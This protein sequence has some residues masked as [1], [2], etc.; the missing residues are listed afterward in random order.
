MYRV[1]FIIGLALLAGVAQSADQSRSAAVERIR[2]AVASVR[3]V[4]YTPTDLRIVAGEV[5]PASAQQI[6]KDLAALREDFQGL[7]MYSGNNGLEEVPAIAHELGFQALILGTWDIASADEI[8]NVIRLARA[9]PELIVGVSVGNEVLLAER[10]EWAMLR[11]A[12]QRLRAALP[13]V[14]V[15]TS[16]PF[17]FYLNE[18]PPDFLSV[19]DFLLPSVH[20]LFETWFP[21]A[22]T[23]RA[24][25]FVVQVAARLTAK[26]DKPV[27]IKETGLPSGPPERGFTLARQTEFWVELSQRLPPAAG[28]GLVYFE[29]FDHAWKVEN[30]EAEFGLRPE[31]AFWGLYEEHGKHKPVIK[32]L[33]RVWD[34]QSRTSGR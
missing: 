15:T 10:H 6:R 4:A 8:A 25:D 28:A 30:A 20:P 18:D 21:E 16:E 9:Y 12:I 7:V 34:A 17:Y 23:E 13:Q 24:V 19:Q 31:E 33:R 1:L 2:A 29:A 5:R 11:D 32:A 3:F 14:A 27:L 22:T 26:T